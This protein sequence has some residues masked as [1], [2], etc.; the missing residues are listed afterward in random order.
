M[1]AI[2]D[3]YSGAVEDTG[4]VWQALSLGDFAM[5]RIAFIFR[6]KQPKKY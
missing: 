3:Y 6:V 2:W 4:L 5:D 1:S